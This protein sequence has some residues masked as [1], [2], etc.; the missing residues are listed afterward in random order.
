M[1]N[2]LHIVGR[3]P[4]PRD[5]QSVATQWLANLLGATYDVHRFSTMQ[6]H[7]ALL[8]KGL[9]GTFYTS[10]HYLRL[11]S[12]LRTALSDGGPVI[13]CSISGQKMGHWRDLITV[14]PAFQPGQ[15]IVASVHW[16]NFSRLFERQLTRYSARRI[17]ERVDCFVLLS[18]LLEAH[19][20]DWIP[21]HKRHV[22]PN[23]VPP[24]G[25]TQE[26]N[27]KHKRRHRSRP[28]RVLYLSNM[29]ESKGYLDV[30][31]ALAIARREGMA[32][33]ADYAGRWNSDADRQAFEARVEALELR[34]IV[35]HHGPITAY[36]RVQA[37]HLAADVFLLPTYYNIEAQPMTI[38]ES[39]SAGT[40]VIVTR[41]A[42]IEAM[43]REDC[44]ALFVP[45]HAPEA[46]AQALISLHNVE[47]WQALSKGARARYESCFS[48][49]VIRNSWTEL[50]QSL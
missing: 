23:F 32:L 15:H 28:L 19:V 41:H 33:E 49:A 24:C 27:Q 45:P 4:P 35:T 14:L 38:I 30:L 21:A 22:I 16:G 46:I 13:W 5:G 36:S 6:E 40:P 39:L 25:S 8:P 2:R 1:H 17:V 50:L 18:K 29:I 7:R 12:N 48:A 31:E 42:S 43:V 34:D 10:C 9:A 26:V 3:F 20:A 47:R 11:K 37:M 44:E